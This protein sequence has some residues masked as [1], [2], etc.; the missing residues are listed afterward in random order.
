MKLKECE[1][2]TLSIGIENVPASSATSA[3]SKTCAVQVSP[4]K[5]YIVRI[6]KGIINLPEIKFC[7]LFKNRLICYSICM[8]W[9]ALEEAL[10]VL[11]TENSYDGYFYC[12]KDAVIWAACVSCRV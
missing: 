4:V 5:R 10:E 6:Y 7:S 11:E 1:N 2:C 3:V 8:R 9:E 12:I